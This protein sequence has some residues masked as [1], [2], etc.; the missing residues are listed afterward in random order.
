MLQ[1]AQWYNF[2]LVRVYGGR[3]A[4]MVAALLFTAALL[5]ARLA[6]APTAEGYRHAVAAAPLGGLFAV[7]A[8]RVLR[9]G[10]EGGVA[11]VGRT[12]GGLPLALSAS[13]QDLLLGTDLGL[14]ASE[15]GGRTWRW[16]GPAGR[17]PA[18]LRDG[19]LLIGGAWGR[20]LEVSSDGGLN[21]QLQRLPGSNEVAAVTDSGGPTWYAATL[22]GVDVSIDR[23]RTW[24]ATAAGSRVTALHT[25]GAGA[26][27][28]TWSGRLYRLNG[29][30]ASEV[31][32]AHAGIW[33]VEGTLLATT[34]GLRGTAD[35]QLAH[36]E[37]TAL[38]ASGAALY[39]GVARGPLYR[40]LDGGVRWLRIAG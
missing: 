10:P 6:A 23:G 25:D 24:Q 7:E 9:I 35:P 14:Q 19:G 2:T 17:Y 29:A 20:G 31:A 13:D 38:V 28:G 39:A 1:R 11:T 4:A 32:D 36:A 40:S 27:A 34:D 15:D 22:T 21:W 33:S 30:A 26:L 16:V 8:T 5:G 37:V 12:L 18:V 3:L